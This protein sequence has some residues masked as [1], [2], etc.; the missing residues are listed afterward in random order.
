MIRRPPRSTRTDTL[1]P[2]ATLFRSERALQILEDRGRRYRIACSS[3]NTEAVAAAVISGL[4]V[5][6][7][8]L[9]AVPEGARI[10]TDAEGFPGFPGSTVMLRR[11]PPA[12]T[13]A[14]D[15]MDDRPEERRGGKEGGRKGKTR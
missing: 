5:A 4:A 8:E 10:L 2:Y 13:R 15:S 3:P 11:H 7:V 12:A 6:V 1:F 9:S 14:V